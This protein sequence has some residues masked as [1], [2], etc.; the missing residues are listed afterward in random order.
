[1]FLTSPTNASVASTGPTRST[2]HVL[3]RWLAGSLLVAAYG[4]L[5]A[6]YAAELWS[7]PHYRLALLL[8]PLVGLVALHRTR[9]AGFLKPGTA[10][11]CLPCWGLSLLL[12]TAASIAG[13]PELAAVAFLIGVLAGVHAIGGQPLVECV[14][15]A[16]LLLWLLA[17]PPLEI[18]L[19]AVETVRLAIVDVSHAALDTVGVLHRAEGQ[20][21]ELVGSQI[22]VDDSC[23][24]LFGLGA[25]V[26]LT[27]LYGAWNRRTAWHTILLVFVAVFWTFVA[28]VAQV[29]GAALLHVPGTATESHELVYAL[30]GWLT[31]T[32]ACVMVF[33][34][35]QLG[36]VFIR[37]AQLRAARRFRVRRS[38]Q[39]QMGAELAP[40]AYRHA[41]RGLVLTSQG[42]LVPVQSM[43]PVPATP[44]VAGECS[45]P[46][47]VRLLFDRG[48]ARFPGLADT[49]LAAVPIVGCACALIVAGQGWLMFSGLPLADDPSHVG[50]VGQALPEQFRGWQRTSDASDADGSRRWYYTSGGKHAEVVVRRTGDVWHE[51][52][53]DYERNGWAVVARRV[54]RS[55][56]GFVDVA[57]Q[58]VGQA[59]YGRLCF[60]VLDSSGAVVAAPPTAGIFALIEAQALGR[61]ERIGRRWNQ[62]FRHTADS[63]SG[64]PERIVANIFWSAYAPPSAQEVEQVHGLLAALVAGI[65]TQ[66]VPAVGN[67]P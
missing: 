59:R 49:C 13:S 12:L 57:L 30:L 45:G 20:A 10:A 52:T 61:L 48:G 21:L 24:T 1:M 29:V 42:E 23:A 47:V 39:K 37:A 38:R 56:P 35:D 5:T 17:R 46:T 33:S 15:P 54:N 41:V 65:R 44:P 63:T 3:G 27:G 6:L 53:R 64:G 7:L 8:A 11:W 9:D 58:N 62:L 55:R 32:L 34:A 60:S 67:P 51:A 28:G 16:W 4:P 31:L 66:S 2:A 14:L 18:D 36:M 43:A 25:I 19:V 26:L 40:H 50:D 22:V